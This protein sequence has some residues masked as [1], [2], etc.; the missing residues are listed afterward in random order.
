V[1]LDG[2]SIIPCSPLCSHM[3]PGTN[4]VSMLCTSPSRL[5]KAVIFRR[6]LWHG[7][8][9]GLRGME[10]IVLRG[11]GKMVKGEG[12]HGVGLQT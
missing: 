5:T 1:V 4:I 8:G 6:L 12:G 9:I 7:G 2:I 10:Y 11:F 3:Y